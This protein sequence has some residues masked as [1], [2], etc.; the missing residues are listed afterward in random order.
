MSEQTNYGGLNSMNDSDQFTSRWTSGICEANAVNIHYL[1][2]GR[3]KP[4][5]IALHGLTGS[6]ACWTPLAR[7]LEDE[8]DVVMP[9]ARGTERRAPHQTGICITTM[10][11]TSLDSSKHWG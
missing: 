10:Q 2:T 7:A 4:T 3:D 6:G 11:A 1:R 8:Y 5:L 9:D